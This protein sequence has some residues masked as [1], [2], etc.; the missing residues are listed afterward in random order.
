MIT[1]QQESYDDIVI[2]IIPLI[3][4][5]YAEVEWGVEN[6]P[7]KPNLE[8]YE[9][10]DK[11]GSIMMFALRDNGELVGYNLFWIYTHPHNSQNYAAN[12]MLYVKPEYRHGGF[13]PVMLTSCE[14]V[15]KESGIKVITYNMK[16]YKTF[17]T[18]MA[19]NAFEHTENVY[20]K[21]IG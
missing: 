1:C 8:A 5:H 20:S 18:L 14:E 15:L 13:A 3:E 7:L 12:D 17:E 9:L 2:D 6:L 4:D 11:A 10:A 19:L 16:P 21:Y